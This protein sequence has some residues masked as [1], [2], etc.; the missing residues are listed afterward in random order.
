MNQNLMLLHSYILCK[1]SQSNCY[2]HNQR[3]SELVLKSDWS[4][5]VQFFIKLNL[6]DLALFSIC[7]VEKLFKSERNLGKQRF[8]YLRILCSVLQCL[9]SFERKFFSQSTAIFKH[10]KLQLTLYN[11]NTHGEL[12]SVRLKNLESPNY[13]KYSKRKPY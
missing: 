8:G 10:S 7:G 3:G 2:V 11:S 5:D 9:P 1:V 13:R 4:R 6:Y 12:R